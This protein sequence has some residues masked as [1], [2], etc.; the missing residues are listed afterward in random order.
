MISSLAKVNQTFFSIR[1]GPF[2][3]YKQIL[4]NSSRD[5][6][7]ISVFRGV[8]QTDF[9]KSCPVF[10]RIFNFRGMSWTDFWKTPPYLDVCSQK[11]VCVTP[12]NSSNLIFRLNALFWMSFP[13]IDLCHAALLMPKNDKIGDWMSFPEIGPAHAPVICQ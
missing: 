12:R 4:E 10:F 9:W 5:F 6:P 11:S 7:E 3:P 8:T 2:N 13:E 1:H